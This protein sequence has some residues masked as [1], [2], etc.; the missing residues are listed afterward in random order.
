M[1]RHRRADTLDER[2]NAVHRVRSRIDGRDRV[3]DGSCIE[4]KRHAGR[5]LASQL[6]RD[7]LSRAVC[8]RNAR[9]FSR[10]RSTHDAAKRSRTAEDQAAA[11]EF[12]SYTPPSMM[13]VSPL[14]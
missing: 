13:I 2:I 11:S 14:I 8:E 9:A 5:N 3:L 7:V 1:H 10:K 4:M 6:I 12:H